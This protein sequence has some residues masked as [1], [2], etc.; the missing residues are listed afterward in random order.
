M[1]R[2]FSL[3][4]YLLAT[5]LFLFF[6]V[7]C[8]QASSLSEMIVFRALQGFAGGVLIPLAFTIVMTMLPPTKRVIGLAGFAVTEPPR[9]CRRLQLLRR[10]SDDKQDDE[11]VFSRG[12]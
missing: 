8:G 4:R 11:Q 9:V 7:L 12:A 3:R 10:W 5:A 1:S 6:S 2:V